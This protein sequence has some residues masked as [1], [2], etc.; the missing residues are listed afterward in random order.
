MQWPLA[1][2]V[3]GEEEEV[4]PNLCIIKYRI[5]GKK[6][7]H[8]VDMDG[9]DT[10]A[11]LLKKLEL[12]DGEIYTF[13]CAAKRLIVKSADEGKM[14]KTLKELR[15]MPTASIVI[16]IGEGKSSDVSKGSLAERNL[17]KKKKTGSHSMHSI[18]LYSQND[19]NK[20]ETFESGGVLYD[21][22][23]SDDEEEEED[24]TAE[25]AEEDGDDNADENSSSDEEV[26]QDDE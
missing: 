19:G 22:V 17:A 15:L 24:A 26:D 9:D 6:K 7:L 2:A 13:T 3:A 8:S 23:L 1:A 11:T 10:L 16:K 14:S 5:E 4:D 21:H 20:A 18:G 25:N 12:D